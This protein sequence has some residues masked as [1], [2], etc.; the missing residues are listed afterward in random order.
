MTFSLYGQ[1]NHLIGII[2]N[3]NI[4]KEVIVPYCTSWFLITVNSK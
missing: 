4:G 3:E 1:V 2:F